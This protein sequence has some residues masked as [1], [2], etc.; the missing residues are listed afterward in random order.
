MENISVEASR[1]LDSILE[2]TQW[3]SS[4]D[5]QGKIYF[6]EENSSKSSWFLPVTEN[7]GHTSAGA[8]PT[9]CMPA[10]KQHESVI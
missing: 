2:Q 4:T 7:S 9:S 8:R 6:Y 3:F 1:M 10:Q 5:P